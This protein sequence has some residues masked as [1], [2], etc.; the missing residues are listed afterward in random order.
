MK[1]R[2]IALSVAAALGGGFA[3]SASA[4]DANY[5]AFNP[6]GVGHIALVPYFSTQSSN[7]TLINITNTDRVNGKVLKVRFRGAS[8]SDDIYDFQVFLSAADMWSAEIRQGADGRSELATSDKSCTLPSNVNGSFITSRVSQQATDI[9]AE[10]R[11]GYVEILTMADIFKDTDPDSDFRALW[12]A[13]KHVS[14]VAP[15]TASVLESLT[16]ENASDFMTAP[17]TG[18]MANWTIINVQRVLAYSGAAASIEARNTSDEDAAVGNLVYWD[19]TSTPLSQQEAEENTADPLLRG[20][21]PVVAGARYD[22]PDMSTPYLPGEPSQTDPRRNPFFQAFAL[23]ASMATTENAFEFFNLASVGAATDVALS[24]PTRRYFAAVKY[25]TTPTISRNAVSDGNIYF[26]S[27][28]SALGSAGTGGKSYQICSTLG[29]NAVRFFDREER[30]TVTSNIV[31]SPG[32]PTS[33]SLCGEV[34]VV[35]INAGATASTATFAEVARSNISNGFTEGWGSIV[36]PNT[37]S[38]TVDFNSIFGSLT[39]TLVGLDDYGLPYLG[40]QFTRV[41]NT[42][43]RKSVV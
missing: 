24:F 11:E 1:K 17:T 13:T 41:S 36:S 9:P 10:T 3:G 37:G 35:G 29:T 21:S 12:D 33:L 43:D 7:V 6:E 25:G 40:T 28:N 5:F 8:N 32:T 18:L 19:Q 16:H 14:G 15:C 4:Q 20:A 30:A 39:G 2:I 23:S 22:L 27:D 34:T 38:F 26:R 31:I 42:T